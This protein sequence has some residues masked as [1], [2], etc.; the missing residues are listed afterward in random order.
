MAPSPHLP[1][2]RPVA[3]A[4][5]R[6]PAGRG[7][8][9]ASGP[10]VLGVAVALAAG[11]TFA[12]HAVAGRMLPPADYGGLGAILAVLVAAA[13]PLSA[14]QGA[15]TVQTARRCAQRLPIGGQRVVLRLTLAAALAATIATALSPLFAAWLRLDGVAA[16]AVAGWWLAVNAPAGVARGL[17][18]GA[19][20]YAAVAASLVTTALAR[21]GF[22]LLLA[23]GGLPGAVGASVLGELTGMAVA[24][25]ACRQAG[26]FG[27]TPTPVRARSADTG[28][29]VRMQVALW[30]FAGSA[31]VLGR[32]VLPDAQ[33][34]SFAAM[35]TAASACLFLPQA[36]ATSALPHFARRGSRRELHL[37]LAATT[38]VGLLSGAPLW[39]APHLTFG[40]L[41][42]DD[43]QPD[44]LV[45]ALLCLHMCGLGALG[46]IAQYAVARRRTIASVVAAAV[47][48]TALGVAAGAHSPLALAAL[49]AATTAPT[50]LIAVL[51]ARGWGAEAAGITPMPVRGWRTGLLAAIHRP[52]DAGGVLVTRRGGPR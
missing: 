11:L 4:S 37:A 3:D 9:V 13:V 45:L 43:L 30:L 44:R 17:L 52:A 5:P 49:L 25:V 31:P 48:L 50:V 42:G 15:V 7:R 19:G 33:L 10:L 29:A 16:P 24:V 14:V 38:A 26:L 6:R 1:A 21:L 2:A 41:F 23:S 22:L 18:I 34:G 46:T 12:F 39:L 36:I 20:R 51:G 8:R 28:R 32:R 40:V 47:A 35:A 27:A